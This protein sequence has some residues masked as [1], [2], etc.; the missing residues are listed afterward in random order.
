M[1]TYGVKFERQILDEIVYVVGNT[2][3]SLQLLY[4]VLSPFS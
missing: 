2:D 1:S 3:I 4:S